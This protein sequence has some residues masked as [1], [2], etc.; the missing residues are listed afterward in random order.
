MEGFFGV[1][2][3]QGVH[4]QYEVDED[5]AV[6]IIAM[7]YYHRDAQAFPKDWNPAEVLNDGARGNIREFVEILRLR[8]LGIHGAKGNML[9]P[10]YFSVRQQCARASATLEYW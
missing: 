4:G 8:V 9:C 5:E 7:A 1:I 3:K 6:K 10:T 2:V